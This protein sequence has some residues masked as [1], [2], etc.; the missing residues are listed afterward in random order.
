MTAGVYY[1][2][3]SVMYDISRLRN[4]P[5]S[6]FLT[7]FVQDIEPT[8]Q[9]RRYIGLRTCP[10]NVRKNRAAKPSAPGNSVFRDGA[11]LAGM[12]IA[13]WDQTYGT[14]YT[15]VNVP[16]VCCSV[17]E[18]ASG[19]WLLTPV[20]DVQAT[21]D[22]DDTNLL[23]IQNLAKQMLAERE[24]LNLERA[25]QGLPPFPPI[26][27]IWTM[28]SSFLLLVCGCETCVAHCSGV[29]SSFQGNRE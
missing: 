20:F 7:L 19:A 17:R 16:W 25:L 27:H 29:Q 24:E 3:F 28:R 18:R 14:M 8:R 4:C 26:N 23:L 10:P 13:E 11:H 5:F 2:A 15:T 22:T 21:G 9:I 6:S 1:S 12:V